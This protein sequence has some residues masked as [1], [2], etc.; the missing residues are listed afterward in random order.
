MTGNKVPLKQLVQSSLEK[1]APLL[2]LCFLCSVNKVWYVTAVHPDNNWKNITWTGDMEKQLPTWCDLETHRDLHNASQREEAEAMTYPGCLWWSKERGETSQ[3]L[4]K[5]NNKMSLD[6]KRSWERARKQPLTHVYS[7][8]ISAFND[9]RGCYTGYLA[10]V[11][12][13]W[14]W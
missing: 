4:G 5:N 6:K 9:V 7:L 14:F 12:S 10:E 1:W 3:I 11:E 13:L 8:E 2:H